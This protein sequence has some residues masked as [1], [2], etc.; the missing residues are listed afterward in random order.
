MGYKR[1]KSTRKLPPDCIKYQ[2]DF[3]YEGNRYRKTETCKRMEVQSVYQKWES[4][5]IDSLSNDKPKMLFEILDEYLESEVEGST[6]LTPAVIKAKIRSIKRFRMC[7]KD[8]IL[9]NFDRGNVEFFINWRSDKVFSIYD[10]TVK[11]GVVSPATIN[12]DLAC[13]SSF[14]TFCIKKKYVQFNPVQ[15]CKLR[16]NNQ[17][18]I[19]LESYQID[20]L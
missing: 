5:I 17:R 4:E 12:R 1:I 7:F 3:H 13:L 18:E 10:N 9:N 19:D 11:K 15:L 20:E 2:F 8:M 16:E 14:F 6:I